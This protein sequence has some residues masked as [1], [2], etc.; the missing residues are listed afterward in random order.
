VWLIQD[1]DLTR[2]HTQQPIHQLE[3]AVKQ[4]IHVDK[5]LIN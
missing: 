3:Q 1:D 5:I 2:F 4:S